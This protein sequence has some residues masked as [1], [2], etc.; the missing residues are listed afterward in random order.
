MRT[1]DIIRVLIVSGAAF[2]TGLHWT[3]LR[4]LVAVRY[5]GVSAAFV[6]L[7]IM[8]VFDQTTR[9]GDGSITWRVFALLAAVVLALPAQRRLIADGKRGPVVLQEEPQHN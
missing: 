5:K 3:I 2:S 1:I 8:G 6:V 7:M 4:N 9:F